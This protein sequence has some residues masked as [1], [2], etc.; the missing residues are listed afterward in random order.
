MEE[1]FFEHSNPFDQFPWKRIT[2]VIWLISLRLFDNLKEFVFAL[3]ELIRHRSYVINSNLWKKLF[4]STPIHL[5]SLFERELLISI[6]WFHWGCLITLRSLCLQSVVLCFLP[7]VSVHIFKNNSP[8]I[9][10]KEFHNMGTKSTT[11]A[12]IFLSSF[13]SL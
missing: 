3:L 6:D 13:H 8:K 7:L 10:L 12:I 9:P 5:I 1:V 4:S 2:D 11:S